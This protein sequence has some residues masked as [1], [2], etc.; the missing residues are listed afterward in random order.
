[1]SS[2]ESERTESP[3]K[4]PPRRFKF[5]LLAIVIGIAGIVAGRYYINSLPYEWTDDAFIE[6]DIIAISP[7]I[8]GQV[9]KVLVQANQ[10]V[11]A[12]D[13]L[14]EIDPEYY[15]E[16]YAQRKATVKLAEAKKRTAEGNVSLTR[17]T[18]KALLQQA[19]AQLREAKAGLDEA[20][21]QVL[22]AEAEALRAEQDFQRHQ[23]DDENIFT[24]REKDLAASLVQVARAG[25][26]KSHKRVTA[27]EAA[28]EVALGRLAD[29]ES[30]PQ[31]VKV[32]KSE[33]AQ[34]AA[35]VDVAIAELKQI[36]IHL[37]HT[38]IYAPRAGRVTRKSIDV[39]EQVRIGQV[40][41]VIVPKEVWVEANFR[42]TQITHMRVGQPVEIRV[43]TY[44]D[45]VFMG[46]VQSIQAGT[47]ARFSLL[48]PQNATGNY[49]KVVQRLPVKILFNEAPDEKFLLVP[50]MS[51]VPRVRVR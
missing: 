39:G 24:Q 16:Q 46:H 11:E 18:S 10:Q 3:P 41:M 20:R 43:D 34:Y 48:P 36:K 12:G 38:K 30:G 26:A 51:V 17:M 49:V 7:Y 6:G 25:L 14:V 13:V 27:S 33:V 42:E 28:I 32:R 8:R 44:R 47:G 50:G 22:A 2:P 9:S 19:T 4:R 31:L 15:A 45:R 37:A 5:V 21:A 23:V 40:I 35:E 29:A 1:M